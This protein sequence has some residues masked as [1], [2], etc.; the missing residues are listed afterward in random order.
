ML[1]GTETP[2]R[3]PERRLLRPGSVSWES[4][5]AAVMFILFAWLLLSSVSDWAGIVADD[6][7]ITYLYGRNLAEGHGLRYNVLDDSATAGASNLLHVF[8]S[9]AFHLL[10]LD[11][12]IATRGLGI[13]LF[14]TIPIAF[15]FMASR[16]NRVSMSVAML[17]AV[18]LT[19]AFSL[20]SGTKLHLVSGMGTMLFTSLNAWVFVW[21]VLLS[22][23]K[24]TLGVKGSLGSALLLTSLALVRP[25]GAVLAVGYVVAVLLIRAYTHQDDAEN[26]AGFRMSVRSLYLMLAFFV[27][28]LAGLIVWK[29]FTFGQLLENAYYV[30]SNN[31]IFGSAGHLLPGLST[32]VKF[33]SLEY[34]P[35]LAIVILGAFSLRLNHKALQPYI[36]LLIPS[37]VVVLLY[38]KAI[39]EMASGFRYEY[40]LLVPLLGVLICV[41]AAL[42]S[43][44]RRGFVAVMGV[45]GIF[46][47]L[48]MSPGS[49]DMLQ[50]ARNPVGSAT[51]WLSFEN[52]R[53]SL[54]KM[55]LDLA[56]T[57]LGNEATILLSG[58]GQ[59]P[60]FS[61]FHAIDWI[62]LNNSYLSGRQTLS[63]EEVWDYL[64]A[65]RPDVVYSI[66]PPASVGVA[67]A[68]EDRGFQSKTVQGYLSGRGSVLFRYWFPERVR[69]MFFLEMMFI[70]D[71]YEF[72]ATYN[73]SDSGEW[74]FA[75]VRR[76]SPHRDILIHTLSNSKRA[77]HTS[78]LSQFFGVDPRQL[79]KREVLP[80]QTIAKDK[81][82][83]R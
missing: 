74:L 5:L 34:L 12:L 50:W 14:L 83:E 51:S 52:D 67:G 46:L 19:F 3:T 6:S 30:K 7:Y 64:E 23:R 47:P 10:G 79:G 11:P 21:A 75:Y 53:N 56:E 58:A 1:L 76:D 24:G 69:E 71:N 16:C 70:R 61:R 29:Y 32:T 55:G 2:G 33:L 72:G 57:G 31:H 63:L 66:L 9:S 15:A 17:A 68:E 77:N 28:G 4:L 42:Y 59:V 82:P 39:H 38:S 49:H 20:V 43:K 80:G 35:L 8:I 22:T 36:I 65:Q 54:A 44:T 27:A 41:G 25:E 45:T 13:F 37:L 60:Y 48:L 26:R 78:E 18:P 81:F 40:P 62:G 73:L